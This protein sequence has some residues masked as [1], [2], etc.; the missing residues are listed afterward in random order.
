MPQ[1]SKICTSAILLYRGK[2]KFSGNNGTAIEKYYDVNT[3]CNEQN[4]LIDKYCKLKRFNVSSDEVNNFTENF[5]IY[6]E[7][8]SEK[9]Y[10]NVMIDVVIMSRELTPVAQINSKILDKE[11]SLSKGQNYFKISILNL[12]LNIGTYKFSCSLTDLEHREQL[13]WIQ[14][15]HE[16]KVVDNFVGHCPIV[17]NGDIIKL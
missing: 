5:D 13:L 6:L 1:V 3:A 2:L 11:V 9:E 12:G 4:T 10:P 14:N 7:V 16:I 8:F 17:L 15:I